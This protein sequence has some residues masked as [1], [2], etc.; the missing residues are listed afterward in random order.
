MFENVTVFFEETTE[1]SAEQR[2][3][4]AYILATKKENNME[5]YGLWCTLF[6]HSYTEDTVTTIT[7]CV[8][9]SVPRCLQEIFVVGECS[10]CGDTYS[11]LNSS[12]YINC[13]N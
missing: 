4:I 11:T 1:F 5:T 7:H 13:C 3:R 6:G 10:R 9:E 2:E 8:R 12:G